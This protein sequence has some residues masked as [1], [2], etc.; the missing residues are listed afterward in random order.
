MISHI[1]SNNISVRLAKTTKHV[2]PKQ[3]FHQVWNICSMTYS[4]HGHISYILEAN[5]KRPK[6]FSLIGRNQM[7]FYNLSEKDLWY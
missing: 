5:S 7:K 3:H 6:D 4:T 1:L 2:S